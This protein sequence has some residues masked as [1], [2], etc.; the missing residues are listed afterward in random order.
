MSAF[1][2]K[3]I[4]DHH[5]REEYQRVKPHSFGIR[6]KWQCLQLIKIL[7]YKILARKQLSLSFTSKL[8]INQVGTRKIC[9]LILAFWEAS[10]YNTFILN[11]CFF[12]YVL[13]PLTWESRNTSELEIWN[14]F[15]LKSFYCLGGIGNICQEKP[16]KETWMNLLLFSRDHSPHS[17]F[18]PLSLY[19]KIKRGCW[20]TTDVHGFCHIVESFFDWFFSVDRIHAM[21]H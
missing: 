10:S 4:F 13:K 16:W 15:K 19:I 1:K 5:Y 20:K 3:H 6:K 18:I 11:I 7:I 9:I 2:R 12:G 17:L 14:E 21:V 8:Q